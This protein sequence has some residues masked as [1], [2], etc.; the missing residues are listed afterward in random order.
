[1]IPLNQARLI[2]D[3]ALEHARANDYPPMTIAVLDAAGQLVAFAKEDNSS[4]LRPAIASAKALGALN[5]GV[6]SRSLA[7]K[8]EQHAAFI[9]AVTILAQGN[10]VPVPGGVLI[11]NTGGIVIG[12]A[13]VSGNLPQHDEECAVAAIE[14]VGL[15]ADPGE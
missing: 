2:V 4:L 9:N 13:G 11:R 10:L 1:M 14:A 7:K 5:M 12:A 15:H 8:A 6:G 3:T